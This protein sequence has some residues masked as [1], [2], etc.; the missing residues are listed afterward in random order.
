MS[1]TDADADGE[2]VNKIAESSGKSDIIIAKHRN[3]PTDTIKLLFQANITKFKNP[4]K[5]TDDI[6]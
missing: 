5:S 4:I 6:F 3:G 2:E 1:R